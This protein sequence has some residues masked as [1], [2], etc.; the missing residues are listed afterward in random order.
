MG[1]DPE[2]RERDETLDDELGS[3]RKQLEKIAERNRGSQ[4]ITRAKVGSNMMTSTNDRK[5]RM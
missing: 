5:T 1:R 4:E 2:R 3:G